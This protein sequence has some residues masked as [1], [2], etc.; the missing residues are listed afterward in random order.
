VESLRKIAGILRGIRRICQIATTAVRFVVLPSFRPKASRAPLPFRLRQALEH[1][2]GAWIKVGQGLAPRFDLLPRE[3]CDEFLKLLSATG[4]FPYADVRNIV[5]REFGHFPEE[6][7]ASFASE[8]AAAA[9]IAQVHRATARDGMQLA[10]KIK[11]PGVDRQFQADFRILRM[12]AFCVNLVNGPVGKSIRLFVDEFERWTMEELDFRNEARHGHRF[13]LFAE[14]DPRQATARIRFEFT[15]S[16][17]LTTEYFDGVS[18]LDI[19]DARRSPDASS[20]IEFRRRGID[21]SRI[22]RNIAWNMLNQMFR[23]GFFHADT[24]PANLIVLPDNVIGYIDFG[25]VGNLSDD[26]RES[27]QR[28]LVHLVQCDFARAVTE[29]LRWMATSSG[30]NVEQARQD[31][32]LIFETY[33][34][35]RGGDAARPLQLT[36][37]FIIDMMSAARR[38]RLTISPGLMLYL[39]A[40]LSID[41]TFHALGPEHDLFREADR[42]FKRAARIDLKQS[43]TAS[44]PSAAGVLDLAHQATRLVSDFRGT[45]AIGRTFQ[46]WLDMLEARLLSYEFWAVVLGVGAYLIFQDDSLQSAQHMLGAGRH[47]LAGAMIVT[48]AAL[49][50]LIWRQGRRLAA[51]D[52]RNRGTRSRLRRKGRR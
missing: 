41:A 9:S 47:W 30:T 28:Y 21:P 5:R 4:T 27:L 43:L 1:L 12:L 32:I 15:T 16:D 14:G 39:K 34:F 37:S 40:V 33:R 29:V 17:V 35:G 26:L 42:F 3:Y 48:M 51:A 6:L 11:K 36:S 10:V 7:F 46:V 20:L 52:H 38:H 18:V 49:L 44:R 19:I 31:L 50:V 24:H 45:Q 13:A 25:I 2:G 8:P 22:A 23:D